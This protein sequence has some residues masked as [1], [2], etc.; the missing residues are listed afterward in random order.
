MSKGIRIFL[1]E[2]L[3]T[4]LKLLV[5]IQKKGQRKKLCAKFWMCDVR[6]YRPCAYASQV[7]SGE[8]FS[9]IKRERNFRTLSG[10]NEIDRNSG[11]ISSFVAHLAGGSFGG[12]F[13]CS[14]YALAL[15]ENFHQFQN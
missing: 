3:T 1:E 7:F 14:N 12:S 15:T 6:I 5:W 4:S 10:R 11:E 2:Y 9:P 13:Q 8:N